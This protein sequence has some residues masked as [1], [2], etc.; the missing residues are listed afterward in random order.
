MANTSR[1]FSPSL[2]NATH[3]NARIFII[4]E[5]VENI[6]KQL[7]THKDDRIYALVATLSY[8]IGG[9]RVTLYKNCTTQGSTLMVYPFMTRHPLH[10][11]TTNMNIMRVVLKMQTSET[12]KPG[13]KPA[14]KSV[15]ILLL[16][17]PVRLLLYDASNNEPPVLPPAD[18]THT[19]DFKL[20]HDNEKTI[21]A[22]I[23]L[24]IKNGPNLNSPALTALPVRAQGGEQETVDLD[25]DEGESDED[26]DEADADYEGGEGTYEDEQEPE[27]VQAQVR[28]IAEIVNNTGTGKKRKHASSGD[29]FMAQIHAAHAS[30]QRALE[31]GPPPAV[32]APTTLAEYME[33]AGDRPNLRALYKLP[34]IAE[35]LDKPA[36][37]H[38]VGQTTRTLIGCMSDRA[39]EELRKEL[40]AKA[41]MES[42]EADFLENWKA[43]DPT[44]RARAF[45]N[46]DESSVEM[47]RENMNRI[48]KPDALE[49]E[50]HRIWETMSEDTRASMLLKLN[51]SPTLA[52]KYFTSLFDTLPDKE[53]HKYY[54]L[55]LE[56]VGKQISH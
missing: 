45:V 56:F 46:F 28:K 52:Y 26:D 1:F 13:N 16:E 14:I 5:S 25:E 22:S 31:I 50:F 35:I 12:T 40:N 47:I 42:H 33:V 53:K 23:I 36:L 54:F 9:D 51:L 11:N 3:K 6:A 20:D 8:A 32:D 21:I 38:T 41:T 29:D 10:P 30:L 7:Y 15:L 49:K 43:M 34:E 44:A 24:A 4:S 2:P 27:E 39:R 37:T 55:A 18:R 19:V 48:A 17:D